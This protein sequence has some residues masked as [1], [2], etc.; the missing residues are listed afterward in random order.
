MTMSDLLSYL[1]LL[2]ELVSIKP[3]ANEVV[4]ASLNSHHK[5]DAIYLSTSV[6]T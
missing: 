4:F 2:V 6:H 1:S 5:H 3:I